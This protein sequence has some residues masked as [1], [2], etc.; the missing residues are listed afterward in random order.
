MDGVIVDSGPYHLKS[1]QHVFQKRS[2]SFTQEDF[3]RNFGQR[4]DSIIRHAMGEQVSDNEI[5]TIALEKESTFRNLVKDNIK[6]FPG[7]IKL[8]SSLL[9]SGFKQALASSG[10]I[11]NIQLIITGLGIKKCFQAIVSGHEVAEGKPSPQ[12]FL[13][14]AN[15]L[16]VKP[17]NCIVVEDAVAGVAAAKKAGMKCLAVT[18]TNPRASL[19]EADLIVDTLEAV[20]IKDLEKLLN[21]K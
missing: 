19:S 9:A 21:T 16:D 11:E 5:N 8:I 1:W 18:N 2:I 15:K 10:P 4:N 12:I 7:V 20:T 13:L 6:P 14:A 3:R 17:E